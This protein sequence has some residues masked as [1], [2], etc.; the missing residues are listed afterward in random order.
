MRKLIFS[1]AGSPFARKVRIV[2][3]EM[4]LAYEQDVR[5]GLRSVDELKCLNPNLA[6]PVLIDGEETLF[7]SNLIIEYLLARYPD[8]AGGA[9]VPFA[10]RMTRLEHHWR[11][12]RTLTTIEA[13]A[14]TMVNVRH[15]RGEGMRGESSRY[16]ARQEARLNSCLD[17]LDAHA[18]PHGFWPGVFSVMD[19]A[20]I[21]PLHYAETRGVIQWR[22]RP[23]LAALYERWGSRH[24]V[25]ETQEPPLKTGLAS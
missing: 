18:T 17:W 2:L 1:S 6:L 20:M 21:C 24:S 10:N 5:P 3:H 9:E 16:M 23:N 15:F 4:G 22:D 19:I 25:W 8:V 14:D 7:G 11:D 12:M 13:F